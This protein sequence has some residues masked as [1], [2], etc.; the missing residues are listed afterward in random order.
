MH[1]FAL[2]A[3]VGTFNCGTARSQGQN[4]NHLY[5]LGTGPTCLY[6][7]YRRGC[8]PASFKVTT[9]G[10]DTF[11]SLTFTVRPSPCRV[12]VDGKNM[13]YT[14]SP[15]SHTWHQSCK[16]VVKR[17][18]GVVIRRCS[19]AQGDYVILSPPHSLAP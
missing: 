15:R 3:I 13:I 18:Y 10:V 6:W 2:L 16:R 14:G 1:V 12:T 7:H 17:N 5:V 4:G 9:M 8:S 19:G 11:A